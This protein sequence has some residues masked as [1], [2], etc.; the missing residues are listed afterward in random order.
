MPSIEK[1]RFVNSGTEATMSALRLARAYTKR[2]R[3]VKFEGCYHGH[4]DHFL[5]QA[6]SGI[7]TFDLPASAGVTASEPTDAMTLEFNDIGAAE[8]AFRRARGRGGGG[9]SRAGRLATWASSPRPPASWRVEEACDEHGSLLVFDEVITGFRVAAG[10]AQELYR[11]K[12]DLTCLGK[13]IGGGFPVGAYG[14][15]REIMELLAPDG[16]V[17]QAGTL[18]GNPVA[19][20]AGLTT[21]SQLDREAPTAGWRRSLR[22]WVG[23]ARR[24]VCEAGSRPR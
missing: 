13:I 14:G 11:I 10:G 4:A 16:P 8:D 21:L 1:V 23:A 20:T 22:A 2:N 5:T 7:A 6:G 12:P 15:R 17:Y 19:M 24:G 9:H 18:S 3:F